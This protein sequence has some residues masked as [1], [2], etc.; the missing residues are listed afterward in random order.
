MKFIFSEIKEDID[1]FKSDIVD[2]NVEKRIKDKVEKYFII[3][4]NN[5]QE[6]DINRKIINKNNLASAIRF[7][8]ILVLFCEKDKNN[9]IKENKKNLMNYLDV[10]DL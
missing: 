10:D 3:K 6:N 2:K 8:M 1:S 9:K 5:D 4:E 7:F